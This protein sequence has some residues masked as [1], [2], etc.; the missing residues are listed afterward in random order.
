MKV[1]TFPFILVLLIS[2]ALFAQ[3]EVSGS[4]K[5]KEL[6]LSGYN[7]ER[8]L[9]DIK[10]GNITI[11]LPGGIVAAP[12]LST[13]VAFEKKYGVRFHSQGCTRF[14]KDNEPAY[15]EE[16]FKYLDLK[17]GKEWRDEI[18]KDAVGFRGKLK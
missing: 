3:Q 15:N 2:S 16:V 6:M 1:K 18:R 14:P 8:A 4:D 13:D 10:M 12:E 5:Q 11:L 7:K 9:S 17:F